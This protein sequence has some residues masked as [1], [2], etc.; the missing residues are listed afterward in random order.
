MRGC[1]QRSASRAPSPSNVEKAFSGFMKSCGFLNRSV[2]TSGS[3]LIDTIVAPR[4]L[5]ASSAVSIRG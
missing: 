2:P 5:A 1:T 3:G 4:A